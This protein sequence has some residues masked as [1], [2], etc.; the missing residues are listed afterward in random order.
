[1][2]SL[3]QYGP[4]LAQVG[5]QLAQGGLKLTARRLKLVQ[6]RPKMSRQR[7]KGAWQKSKVARQ[8][9]NVARQQS[10]VAWQ[11]SKV[12]WQNSKAAWQK[13][14][15]AW[16]KSEVVWQQSKCGRCL[17]YDRIPNHKAPQ[18]LWRRSFGGNFN[19]GISVMV[20]WRPMILS[21]GIRNT[22]ECR[23]TK[24]PRSSRD[25]HSVATSI[26]GFRSWPYGGL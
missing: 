3:Y 12:A 24:L 6:R 5:D 2:F 25:G 15:V 18:K 23:I 21:S 1:M 19:R 16:Q 11:K 17:S 22:S 14:K 13:S 20:P 9:S 4:K 8:H 7:S 10:K 26:V